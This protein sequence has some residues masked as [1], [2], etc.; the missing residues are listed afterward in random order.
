MRKDGR[1]P[2]Q[3]DWERASGFSRVEILWICLPVGVGGR[4][5][6]EDKGEKR[7]FLKMTFWLG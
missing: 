5:E 6:E 2:W 3:S 7:K 4:V 1:S